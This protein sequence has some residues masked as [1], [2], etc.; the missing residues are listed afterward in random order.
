MVVKVLQ[1]N[2]IPLSLSHSVR[3]NF[4]FLAENS[5]LLRIFCFRFGKGLNGCVT[6]NWLSI[7]CLGFFN[8]TSSINCAADGFVKSCKLILTYVGHFQNQVI[9][10]I[11]NQSV[12]IPF[13]TWV[14]WVLVAEFVYQ[15][16]G[17][18]LTFCLLFVI[19]GLRLSAW[20]LGV[21]LWS[22]VITY[23]N[24]CGS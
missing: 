15:K 7:F 1:N 18:L 8:A 11:L 14:D 4:L 16:L 5:T 10:F 13:R 20:L 22:A 9:H 12:K 21:H 24:R 17:K 23:L 3:L 2:F 19:L 6:F